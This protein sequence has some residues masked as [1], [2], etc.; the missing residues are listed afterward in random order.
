MYNPIPGHQYIFSTYC[1]PSYQ[2]YNKD[3]VVVSALDPN[4]GES[5]LQIIEDPVVQVYVTKEAL[6]THVEKKE[7]EHLNNLDTYICKYKSM[8]DYLA[9]V[10][11]NNR[12][13]K[14]SPRMVVAR[15]PFCYGWDID[16]T[17]RV[18]LEYLNA[19]DQSIKSLS[20][21]MLDIETSVMGDEQILCASVVVWKTRTV[22]CFILKSWLKDHT[23]EELDKRTK[24]EYVLFAEGLNNKARSI[25]D[26]Q[27][28]QAKYHIIDNEKTLIIQLISCINYYKLNAIGV[29]NMGYDI[30]YIIKRAEFRQIDLPNLFCHK[31]VPKQ[32]RSF[33]FIEDKSNPAHF[34][35][36]WHNVKCPGY[37][38]YYDAMCLYSLIRKV[39]GK[40]NYYTLDYIGNKIIGTG[41]MHFGTNKTHYDMQV[42]D[43]VG[44]CVYN[45][46]DVIIPAI[47][48]E[49]TNDVQSMLMLLGPSN[50]ADF[51]R[52]TVQLKDQFFDYLSNK[53][54][55]PGSVRGSIK[56]DHDDYIGNIGGAVLNPALMKERGISCLKESNVRSTI[57][58]L[59]NDLDVSSFY[60]S[61]AIAFNVSKETKLSTVLYMDGCPYTL[62]QIDHEENLDKKKN[63]AIA[64]TEYI[65]NYFSRYPCIKENAVALCSEYFGLPNYDEMLK[66]VLSRINQQGENR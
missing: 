43:P 5:K 66:T 62:A 49:I 28:V 7:Y 16:I 42:N 39:K 32:Y 41:K 8:F 15:S 57:Y 61:I 44:Y 2:S 54:C 36:T 47:M 64:N 60:P 34:S 1:P 10:L 51:N 12:T 31:D 9:D 53:Q 22:H 27:P 33:E 21:G 23:L 18:K 29:W 13:M 3:A 52:Q 17:T 38:F 14:M 65:D 59:T 55:V 26:K 6:R 46:M 58:R 35:E 48:D 40:E 25:W 20:K 50:I 4:T 19:N 45:T 11:Y 30:P 24:T 63:M 56:T 37:G